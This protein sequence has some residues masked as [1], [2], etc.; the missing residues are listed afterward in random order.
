MERTKKVY[1]PAVGLVENRE[2]EPMVDVSCGDKSFLLPAGLGVTQVRP[3]TEVSE[4]GTPDLP[5]TIATETPES[6]K[7]QRIF[8]PRSD[9][10]DKR[11]RCAQDRTSGGR[12]IVNDTNHVFLSIPGLNHDYFPTLVRGLALTNFC[13]SVNQRRFLLVL[14]SPLL[15]PSVPRPSTSQISANTR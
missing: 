4:V 2:R 5:S 8:K 10:R 11:M 9:R 6:K 1:Q 15:L 14:S 12:G 7:G 13:Y 3:V